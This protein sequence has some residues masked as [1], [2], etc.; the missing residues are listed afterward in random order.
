MKL[1]SNHSFIRHRTGV[2]L[3]ECLVYVVVFAILLGLGTAAFY[4]CW[5]HTRATI[6]TTSEI[7]AALHAGETWRADIRAATGKIS[8]TA[9]PEGELV[10]IPA[11]TGKVIYRFTSGELR[12]EIPTLNRSHV[13]V[14]K[15]LASAMWAE[16]REGVSAWRWE[17]ELTPPRHEQP[18][19]LQFI[20]E[21]V[22]TT[23]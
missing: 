2:V 20:F 6:G 1:P 22:P 10:E 18:F 17:L 5:D 9:T 12:R 8:V 4:F 23:P 3:L 13:L 15:T 16:P 21:A 19:P 11:R 14:E 7:A